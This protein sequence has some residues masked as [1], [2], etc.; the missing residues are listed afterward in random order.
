MHII[1]PL[2]GES[3]DKAVFGTMAKC[4]AFLA[5]ATTDYGAN[6]GNTA[7]TYHEVRTWK[8]GYQPKGKPLIPLRMVRARAFLFLLCRDIYDP[9][10]AA[11][12]DSVGRRV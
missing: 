3:I 11:R 5:M 6:T 8:E 4:D 12:T 1:A 7:S 2:P 10:C 9:E